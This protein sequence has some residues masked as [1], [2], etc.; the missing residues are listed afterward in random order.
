MMP[1]KS[2]VGRRELKK[3]E[4]P[5]SVNPV[6]RASSCSAEKLKNRPAREC[7]TSV[8]NACKQLIGRNIDEPLTAV[9]ADCGLL[10]MAIAG[11]NGH[12]MLLKHEL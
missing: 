5:R 9:P 8:L 3:K 12:C 1:R 6:L 11:S 2:E 7:L 10:R 4:A